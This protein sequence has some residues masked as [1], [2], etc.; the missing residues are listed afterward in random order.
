VAVSDRVASLEVQ[1]A[2]L[3]AMGLR[4]SAVED[5]VEALENRQNPAVYYPREEKVADVRRQIAKLAGSTLR[6]CCESTVVE[7]HTSQCEEVDG[8]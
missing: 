6:D 7:P 3:K 1:V 4:L 8:A 2:L 5:L